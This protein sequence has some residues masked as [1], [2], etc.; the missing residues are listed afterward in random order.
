MATKEKPDYQFRLLFGLF[1]LADVVVI[2]VVSMG[3]QS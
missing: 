1:A 2:L 3:L